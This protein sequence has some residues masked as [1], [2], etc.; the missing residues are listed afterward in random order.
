MTVS[1]SL[2][3]CVV[4]TVVARLLPT[5]RASSTSSPDESAGNA[6][7]AVLMLTSSQ[8]NYFSQ[9]LVTSG[10]AESLLEIAT[11]NGSYQLHL[12]SLDT[13]VL[14]RNDTYTYF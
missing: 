9:P 1:L 10:W 14:Y 6:S 8:P 2:V 11:A 4:L 7:L 3:S 13:Q 12:L 5:L